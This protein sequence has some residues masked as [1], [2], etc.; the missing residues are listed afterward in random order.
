[1]KWAVPMRLA[2]EFSYIL[3]FAARLCAVPRRN[4]QCNIDINQGQQM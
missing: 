4:E 3:Y 1:M 2:K